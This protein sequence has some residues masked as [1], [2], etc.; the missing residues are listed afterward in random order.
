MRAGRHAC[1][2]PSRSP[3]RCRTVP[4][5]EAGTASVSVTVPAGVADGRVELTLRGT[6][7]GTTVT[8]PVRTSD[9]LPTPP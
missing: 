1:S 8:V 4:F 2:G 6:T 9:G 7:T 5:D 3:T